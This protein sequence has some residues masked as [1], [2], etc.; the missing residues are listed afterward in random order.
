MKRTSCKMKIAAL[1]A[2]GYTFAHA[3]VNDAEK[4]VV[5]TREIMAV[6]VS[7]AETWDKPVVVCGVL[8]KIG[9]G[10]LTIPAEQLYGAGRIDVAEGELEITATGAGS[11]AFA[12]PTSVMLGAAM[13]LDA[14]MHVAGAS[15]AVAAS[16]DA[17]K[18]YDVR[19]TD[20]ETPG[21]M[22]NYIHAQ[23]YNNLATGGLWPQVGTD[24]SSRPYVDF[25]GVGSGQYMTW[26]TPSGTKAWIPVVHSFVV[27]SPNGG[28]GH[29]LGVA[30]SPSEDNGK[31]MYF[32]TSDVGN[33]TTLFAWQPDNIGHI[34]HLGRVFRD[35]VQTDPAATIDKSATQLIE[36]EAYRPDARAEAFFNFRNYQQ[37]AGSYNYGNRVGGGRL[38]EVLIFTNALSEADRILVEQRLLRKWINTSGYAIPP[39][40]TVACGATLTL[41]NAVFGLTR[42]K[43]EGTLRCPG[44]AVST[45]GAIDPF[46][47]SGN[48]ELDAGA[49]VSNRASIAVAP[50]SGKAYAVDAWN[51]LTVSDG[52]A[53]QVD[54]TGVGQLAFVGF[55]DATKV[56]VA[57]GIAS[58]H[59]TKVRRSVSENCIADGG[60]EGLY[61]DMNYKIYGDG[62]QI[63]SSAWYV[64]NFCASASTR[65]CYKTAAGVDFMWRDG[66]VLGAPEG[67]YYLLFKNGSGARQSFSIE[68]AGRHEVR[69]RCY[70]RSD[71]NYYSAFARVY[72][73]G[74]PIGTAQC[75]P[76]ENDWDAVRLITPYLEAGDHVLSLIS[77]VTTDN[78][79]G[80]DDVRVVLLDEDRD[81]FCVANGNFEDIDW[82]VA[83]SQPGASQSAGAAISYAIFAEGDTYVASRIMSTAYL[84]GWT[85]TGAAYLLRRLPYLRSSGDFIGPDNDNGCVSIA[86][87]NG[88]VLSQSVTIPAT[89][90]YRLHAKA[91]RYKHPAAQQF[92]GAP[93]DSCKMSLAIGDTSDVFTITG[94]A[95]ADFAM[96]QS[97]FLS[98]GDVVTISVTS[99]DT[100]GKG[101]TIVVDD[102]RLVREGNLVQN[103][104]FET[105]GSSASA[106]TGWTLVANPQ[107]KQLKYSGY[108]TNFG[109]A[110]VE[111]V[112]RCRIHA[113]T[114]IEQTIPLSAGYYWLSFWNVSRSES[115]TTAKAF[116]VLYGPAAI[117]VTLASGSVTNFCE[118]VVPSS[119]CVEF[120]RREFLVKV[121]SSGNWTLGFE[122]ETS[123][124][125]ISSFIDAVSLRPASDVEANAVPVARSDLELAIGSDASLQLDYDGVLYAGRLSRGARSFPDMQ[126]AATFSNLHGI[127]YIFTR[128][129]GFS[130]IVK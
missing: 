95:L 8:R 5:G 3:Y 75:R 57:Q 40:M 64:A 122:G 101:N 74:H 15:G 113:G 16:G 82:A 93:T 49:I 89:G 33:G 116:R 22:P 92:I 85:A 23:A 119:N 27:Y 84:K 68:K 35:G 21:F 60:F 65:I 86:L 43:S 9:A 61:K 67:D 36:T 69:L 31:L 54:K 20:L 104:G 1:T 30:T 46:A 100:V 115:N 91:A 98:E 102:V 2:V 78:A 44:S 97:V 50:Q 129:L 114:H 125:D 47:V 112:A 48:V 66:K 32:S 94:W 90:L 14:S 25:G 56:S 81:S 99:T 62:E 103:G 106:L 127:G 126:S 117:T 83:P 105:G 37:S 130:I 118:T 18:W 13:W 41:P 28:H 77:E 55:D 121:E 111:G 124:A 4:A 24:D 6:E 38:H 71:Y 39:E 7:S 52:T 107:N 80:I 70:P 123:S 73:D 45:L 87:T 96:S 110:P 26:L 72:V 10:K 109:A 29:V 79:I 120:I 53:G 59:A 34:L 51:T 108:N 88:T 17:V 58:V 11:A 63:G 128:P 42:V 12:E 19:E 76:G